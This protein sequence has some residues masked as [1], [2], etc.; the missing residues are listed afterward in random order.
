M[1]MKL[2]VLVHLLN[3]TG[4]SNPSKPNKGGPSQA[5]GT[6]DHARQ[7]CIVNPLKLNKT[8]SKEISDLYI[9]LFAYIYTTILSQARRLCFATANI[10]I[11]LQQLTSFQLI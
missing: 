11:G 9:S 7:A 1:S 3:L 5:R 2:Y 6:T 4:Q 10:R 8:L